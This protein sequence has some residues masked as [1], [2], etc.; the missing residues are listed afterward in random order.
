MYC[1]IPQAPLMLS[2]SKH[3]R[4]A[5]LLVLAGCAKPG[6]EAPKG[7]RIACAIDGATQFAEVCTV[8]R[9]DP[10]FTI[11]RPDG[12]FRRFEAASDIGIAAIPRSLSAA[13]GSEA[14]QVA[15]LADGSVE[16]AIGSDRY[17]LKVTFRD[18][19]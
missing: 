14:L 18:S 12:G 13:D 1:P 19:D 16:L 4:W 7:E 11:H 9:G 10:Q 17:R 2:L 3:A 6:A 15:P 5:G 8:E